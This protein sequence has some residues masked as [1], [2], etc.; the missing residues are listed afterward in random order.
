MK[1]TE[2]FRKEIVHFAKTGRP[3]TSSWQ[4]FPAKTAI[5]NG[6][7]S[8]VDQYHKEECAFWAKEGLLSYSW[9]N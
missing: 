8:I 6:G 4:T 9:I 1:L 5:V 7:I 3:Y 2:I